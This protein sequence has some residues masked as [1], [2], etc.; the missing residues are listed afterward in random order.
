[1]LSG[2]ILKERLSLCILC[3]ISGIFVTVIKKKQPDAYPAAEEK[4]L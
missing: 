2:V 4:T 1:M 3:V